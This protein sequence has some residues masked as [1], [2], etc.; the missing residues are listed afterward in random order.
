[1]KKKARSLK[2]KCKS[3]ALPES[4]VHELLEMHQEEVSTWRIFKI[5]TEFVSGFEFLR[6]YKGQSISIFGTARCKTD[7]KI[8][9][10]ARKLAYKLAKSKFAVITGGG[11]G[12]MEAANRGAYEAGGRSVGINIQLP[13]EQ[14]INRYVKESKAFEHFFVRKVMLSFA[15]IVYVFFPGGY[16]TLDEFFEM[17]T[18]IQTEKIEP[19]P[20]VLVGKDFWEPLMDWI[21][22][23]VYKKNKAIAKEDLAIVKV[24]DDADEAYSYIKGLKIK[25]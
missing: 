5:M 18:L 19:I 2:T 13:T 11:P 8:Y 25:I 24:V 4:K 20:V 12:V 7:S 6:K 9:K 21:Q 17:L 16:G 22:T 15:S 3:A 14:R 10:E 1:M 23:T